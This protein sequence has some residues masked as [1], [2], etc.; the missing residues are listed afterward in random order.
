MWWCDNCEQ[1]IENPV[2]CSDSGGRFL[3]CP[4][5]GETVSGAE[6][7]GC[8]AYIA[9]YEMFCESCKDFIANIDLTL[10]SA[11]EDFTGHEVT[12]EHLHTLIDKY[13]LED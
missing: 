1:L 10:A 12:L 5:C 8:G 4:H 9:P 3:A 7:C 2:E 13:Y 6:V 11:Y